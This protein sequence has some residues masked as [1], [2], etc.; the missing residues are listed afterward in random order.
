MGAQ[1]KTVKVKPFP[2]KAK[3]IVGETPVDGQILK[4]TNTG[5]LIEAPVPGLKTGAKF[6]VA[7]TIPL[8]THEV[9]EACVLVKLYTSVESHVIE[10]HFVSVS[11]ANEGK[12]LKFL[13]TITRSSSGAKE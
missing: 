5:F 11:A 3:M 1:V 4:L 8:T 10:G 7:F 9:K 6:Q 12:I 2:I 13:N